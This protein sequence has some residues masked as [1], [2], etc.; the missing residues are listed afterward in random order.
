MQ[1]FTLA[2]SWN[3]CAAT[4]FLVVTYDQL[5]YWITVYQ[6]LLA[7]LSTMSHYVRSQKHSRH[8]VTVHQEL[9]FLHNI[10]TFTKSWCYMTLP[11][12]KAVNGKL[13]VLVTPKKWKTK[14]AEKVIIVFD[15]LGNQYQHAVPQ[16]TI[17]WRYLM[18][19][20]KF[21]TKTTSGT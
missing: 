14:C 20:A 19:N 9:I 21:Q 15:H 6:E 17:S 8:Q 5:E 2:Q 4:G 7:I 12:N 3:K 1:T 11:K 13:S 16:C 18:P 10:I